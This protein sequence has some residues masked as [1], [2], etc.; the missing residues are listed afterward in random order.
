MILFVN[1]SRP[2]ITSPHTPSN[3]RLF[4]VEALWGWLLPLLQTTMDTVS[5]ETLRDWFQA[6][7]LIAVI[8]VFWGALIYLD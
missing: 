3:R 4:Q 8:D 1:A 2:I 6:Y 7:G 5:V